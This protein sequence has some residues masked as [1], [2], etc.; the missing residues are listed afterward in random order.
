MT[1]T[2]MESAAKAENTEVVRMDCQWLPREEALQYS[3]FSLSLHQVNFD[4]CGHAQ[5]VKSS[6]R[7]P[8]H[9]TGRAATLPVNTS[10]FS[11]PQENTCVSGALWKGSSFPFLGS[12]LMD[13]VIFQRFL[14]NS[15]K[16]IRTHPSNK[17]NHRYCTRP[18]TVEKDWERRDI[19]PNFD[20]SCAPVLWA[21]KGT[22]CQSLQTMTGW[23]PLLF[24]TFTFLCWSGE[25]IT[26]CWGSW[27]TSPSHR[28]TDL[29]LCVCWAC[30]GVWTRVCVCVC[31][32]GCGCVWPYVWPMC[33]HVNLSERIYACMCVV[34]CVCLRCV[35]VRSCTNQCPNKA[36]LPT[37]CPV[38][39]PWKTKVKITRM[40]CWYRMTN[41]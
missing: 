12:K 23:L 4:C 9:R 24:V 21:F 41:V 10:S 31:V 7:L 5:K 39:Q 27:V 8:E 29:P 32:C 37:V 3:G 36:F 28:C 16:N 26:Y 34:V 2:K 18:C 22:F 17:S 13:R 1:E 19:V 11:L 20:T 15:K 25:N 35:Y 40:K 6:S 38:L 33:V 14:I 30:V